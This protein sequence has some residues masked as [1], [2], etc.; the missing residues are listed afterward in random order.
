[1][2]TNKKIIPLAMLVLGA[3]ITVYALI[4]DLTGATGELR[5]DILILG[6]ILLIVGRFKMP[7]K[8]HTKIVK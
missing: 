6:V 1:M 5:G 7:H 2:N 8:K 3:I 4:L